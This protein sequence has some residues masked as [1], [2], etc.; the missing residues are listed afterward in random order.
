MPGRKLHINPF[1]PLATGK[2]LLPVVLT[3]AQSSG[4]VFL[5]FQ[6]F[7]SKKMTIF[8][9]KMTLKRL[10]ILDFDILTWSFF[11]Q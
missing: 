5:L 1:N 10:S 7:F 2:L 4:P 6:T 8:L 9:L 3:R 11:I